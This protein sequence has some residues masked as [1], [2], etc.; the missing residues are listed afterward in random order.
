MSCQL[1]MTNV[2]KYSCN[3]DD[4]INNNTN[5]VLGQQTG[6][7]RVIQ[8][9]LKFEDKSKRE[10]ERNQLEDKLHHLRVIQTHDSH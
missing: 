6:L 5:L 7:V 3:D 2:V 10:R 4:N 8:P 1:R 9:K